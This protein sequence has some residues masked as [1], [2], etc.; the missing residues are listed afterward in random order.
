MTARLLT[1][2]LLLAAAAAALPA[3][4]TPQSDLDQF[5]GT[6]AV[7]SMVIDGRP[8]PEDARAKMTVTVRKDKLVMEGP[9][10]SPKKG[11]TQRREFAIKLDPSKQPKALD[12][13]ALDGRYKGKTM[14]AIYRLEGDTLTL[15]SSNQPPG[16]KAP[17]RPTEFE[18]VR[19]SMLMVI[20][21]KR[22]PAAR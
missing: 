18:S 10:G 21:L 13:T 4:D 7:T 1:G 12:E 16:Q 3:G 5:Q 20:K 6:W 22:K 17:S 15:C 8:V 14:P 11:V 19:G 9:V 2:S